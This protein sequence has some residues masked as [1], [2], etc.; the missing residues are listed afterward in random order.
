MIKVV[1]RRG[2]VAETMVRAWASD[3]F[4]LGAFGLTDAMDRYPDLHL[5]TSLTFAGDIHP[6]YLQDLVEYGY[7]ALPGGSKNANYY[8]RT[9]DIDSVNAYF[10][11][12][13]PDGKDYPGNLPP[14]ASL[15]KFRRQNATDGLGSMALLME[16]YARLIRYIAPD[17]GTFMIINQTYKP[18][19]YFMYGKIPDIPAADIY[20]HTTGEDPYTI[21]Q[22]LN[23]A[24]LASMP[25]P[26]Y[27]VP[28]FVQ[29]SFSNR[30]WKR[31]VTTEEF[32]LRVLYSIAAGAKGLIWYV[33]D[34]SVHWTPKVEQQM[35]LMNGR[36]EIAGPVLQIGHPVPDEWSTGNNE[37]LMVRTLLC[38][39]ETI[40]VTLINTNYQA[41]SDGFQ[42]EP[43]PDARVRVT[44]PTSMNIT[45]C[46]AALPGESPDIPFKRDG[47]GIIIEAGNVE[48]GDFFIC[49][50]NP[51]LKETLR[52][53]WENLVNHRNTVRTRR[54]AR[55]ERKLAIINDDRYRV[56]EAQAIEANAVP[57]K[58]LWNPLH[59]ENNALQWRAD[60]AGEKK[61][62]VWKFTIDKANVP[63]L[64]GLHL[65]GRLERSG[66]NAFDIYLKNAQGELV[67]TNAVEIAH[68]HGAAEWGDY[69]P[70]N[71]P[72]E[73]EVE[74]PATGEYTLE[75][76]QGRQPHRWFPST[77]QVARQIYVMPKNESHPLRRK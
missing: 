1:S 65:F 27:S 71:Y 25:R 36:L 11:F 41:T 51:A 29:Q 75:L 59:E 10:F 43:I 31:P 3:F 20:P 8:Y 72:F 50:G 30:F 16:D 42:Y 49:T 76:W 61:G 45:H 37:K 68:V 55:W 26:T 74:F 53:R 6:H 19:N 52:R 9:K 13:E 14:T 24:R 73:W 77:A 38:G 44:L 33:F 54:K 56:S 18:D 4:P 46:F 60:A 70:I 23:A 34:G 17:K 69:A 7:K 21:Y 66:G 2:E 57:A 48:T 63:Y 35:K 62:A 47:A 5:N 40:I 64:I 67:K 32:D 12:D 15:A 58:S 39:N 22:G 28:D